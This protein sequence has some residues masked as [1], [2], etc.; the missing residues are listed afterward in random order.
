MATRVTPRAGSASLH[1]HESRHGQPSVI[2]DV[3]QKKE[4]PAFFDDNQ[5]KGRQ[6]RTNMKTILPSITIALALSL[7]VAKADSIPIT[8]PEFGSGFVGSLSGW[9]TTGS[10]HP[11]YV[12]SDSGT[13]PLLMFLFG[14]GHSSPPPVA[15]ASQTL[16]ASL[17]DMSI[18]TLSFDIR[19]NQSYDIPAAFAARL[20]AGATLLAETS[21]TTPALTS[22]WQRWSYDFEVSNDN[23]NIGSP[24]K[25]EFFT[26]AKLYPA[27]TQ[28]LDID[29]V[30]LSVQQVPEPAI[31]SLLL[32]SGIGL[33]FLRRHSLAQSIISKHK[34]I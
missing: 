32:I 30:A 23:L 34:S 16:S 31:F 21:S 14:G 8:N 5:R 25:I 20:Y 7:S 17:S 29:N 6:P 1:W 15:Y 18:Y 9:S 26:Q 24:L 11:S 4:K 27:G 12:R 22:N 13:G 2:A 19:R 33:A 28:R 3:R 10:T